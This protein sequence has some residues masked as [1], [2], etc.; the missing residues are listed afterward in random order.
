MEN[1]PFFEG[2]P[3]VYKFLLLILFVIIGFSFSN[4]LAL[5]LA[6]LFWDQT[7]ITVLPEAIRF[8]LL[9]SSLCVFFLPAYLYLFLEKNNFSKTPKK[10]PEWKMKKRNMKKW[11]VRKWIWRKENVKKGIWPKFDR[12][13][14]FVM[15]K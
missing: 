15:S 5:L 2:K 6:G 4:I 10:H 11:N 12:S 13:T 7:Q 3:P 9:L 14:Y 8:V 1:A